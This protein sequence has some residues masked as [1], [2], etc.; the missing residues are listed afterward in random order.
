M[1]RWT[2]LALG[3]LA[4]LLAACPESGPRIEPLPE[5]PTDLSRR[6]GGGSG[7]SEPAAPPRV[8][9]AVAAHGFQLVAPDDATRLLAA[10]EAGKIHPAAVA[11]MRRGNDCLAIVVPIS[12]AAGASLKA[13]ARERLD[14]IGLESPEIVWNDL[15][16]FCEEPAVRAAVNGRRDGRS[17]RAQQT[18][19]LS[20]GD[21]PPRGW[22][23]RVESTAAL[24]GEARRC[25]DRL[26]AAFELTDGI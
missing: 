14:A 13:T 2:A 23:V 5:T 22:E 1:R 8:K 19:L 26:T 6:T 4:T 15:V 16:R 10:E 24:F 20:T 11:A 7:P 3:G 18:V 9:L 17:V 21:G 12:V 25:H